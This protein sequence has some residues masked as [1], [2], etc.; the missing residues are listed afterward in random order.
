MDRARLYV[1]LQDLYTFTDYLG[2]DP[3]FRGG[4]LTPG[5]DGGGAYP[6]PRTIGLG[7]DIGF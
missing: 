3:E 6:T 4:T 7:I 5:E 1:N 2:Y